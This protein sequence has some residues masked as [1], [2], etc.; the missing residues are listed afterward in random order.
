MRPRID[1]IDEIRFAAKTGFLSKNIW[2]KFFAP[3]S[4]SW[5]SRRWRSFVAS[6]IFVPHPSSTA[7]DVLVL[8][9]E[10]KLVVS[11][12]RRNISSPPFVAQLQHDEIAA[13]GMQR[14]L[15]ERVITNFL[16][17]SEQR[18]MFV[19]PEHEVDRT[20]KA[21]YPDG[22]LRIGSQEHGLLLALEIELTRKSRKRYQD[23]FTR[24]ESL[25]LTTGIVF[26]TAT[27]GTFSGIHKAMKAHGFN[28]HRCPVG[29]CNLEDWQK[30]PRTA[31]IK[32]DGWTTS[33]EKIHQKKTFK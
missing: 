19:K 20:K 33:L 7:K 25:D 18:R 4:K 21:K 30:S 22:V 28:V 24:Y 9:P 3:P 10:N 2:R 12:V 31:P 16:T 6:K 29:F 5:Q 27:S 17:E 8:N 11:T 1:P 14:L 26:V 13:E 15:N 32:F 23:I